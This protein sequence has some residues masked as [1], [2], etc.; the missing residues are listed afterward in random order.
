M[1]LL[2]ARGVTLSVPGRTLFRD[3]SLSVREGM[4]LGVVGPSGSGKTQLLRAV[5]GLRDP[6]AGEFLLSGEKLGDIPYP[7]WRSKVTYLA[8]HA[9]MLK[10]T[11]RDNLE[12]PF[13]YAN[14]R[15]EFDASVA[16]RQLEQMGLE[17]GV[18]EQDARSLSVGEQQR[19]ALV[20][21]IGIGPEVLLLDE[22]TSALD[23]E[24]VEAVETWLKA[25]TEGGLGGVVVSHDPAQIARLTDTQVDLKAFGAGGKDA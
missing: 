8:Q 13:C 16:A 15:R 18:L 11:V 24:S 10:G 9:V 3:L 2:S 4:W 5:A 22:P 20:R 17:P 14:A 19:V 21:G 1:T 23:T 6:D 12:R 25:R 7:Q